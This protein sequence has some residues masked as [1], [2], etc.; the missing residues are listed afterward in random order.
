MRVNQLFMCGLMVR[1]N[2]KYIAK[3][4]IFDEHEIVSQAKQ[5]SVYDLETKQRITTIKLTPSYWV[6]PNIAAKKGNT[7]ISSVYSFQVDPKN[8]KIMYGVIYEK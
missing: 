8:D 6:N 2:R 7:S 1:L 5:Y 4:L 3:Y